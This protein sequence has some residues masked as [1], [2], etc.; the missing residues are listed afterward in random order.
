MRKHLELA[1]ASSGDDAKSRPSVPGRPVCR[2][3]LRLI[4]RC[5]YHVHL[6][7]RR[8][9]LPAAPS[10]GTE[11]WRQDVHLLCTELVFD[12]LRAVLA[13]LPVIQPSLQPV[14]LSELPLETLLGTEQIARATQR[15]KHISPQDED[16]LRLVYVEG[17]SYAEIA[18]RR[19][20]ASEADFVAHYR[21]VRARWARFATEDG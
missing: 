4:K 7:R 8:H 13:P 18:R 2:K 21:D 12:A 3:I 6:H 11:E 1:V 5:G 19:G 17:L 15:V 9:P 20:F 14:R 10:F 16:L